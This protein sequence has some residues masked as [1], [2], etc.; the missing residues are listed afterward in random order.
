M[1]AAGHEGQQ[2]VEL[3]AVTEHLAHLLGLLQDVEAAEES[4]AGRG[5]HITGKDLH[6]RGFSGTY[7]VKTWR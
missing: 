6:G 1:F 2:G 7:R 5:V 3:R 4:S